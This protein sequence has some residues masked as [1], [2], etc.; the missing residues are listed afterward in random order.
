MAAYYETLHGAHTDYVD[1]GELTG[2]LD[3]EQFTM[4]T[5]A[6]VRKQTPPSDGMPIGHFIVVLV[7]LTLFV[8]II[9]ILIVVIVRKK[10]SAPPVPKSSK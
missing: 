8:A 7:C 1:Y 4:E 2:T 3:Y 5:K 10:I 9:T 6:F